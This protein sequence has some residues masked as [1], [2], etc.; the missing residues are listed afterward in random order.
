LRRLLSQL[1]SRITTRSAHAPAGDTRLS[2]LERRLARVDKRLDTLGRLATD[3]RLLLK[4][5][6]TLASA[7]GGRGKRSPAADAP[8]AAVEALQP[9]DAADW[10]TLDACPACGHR[11]ATV[12]CEY[13]RFVV[14]DVG[15]GLGDATYNYSLCHGC[16]VVFAA[17]RPTGA[18][19]RELLHAFSENLGRASRAP[20]LLNPRPLQAEERDDLSRRLSNGVFVSEH[21]GARNRD[22]LPAVLRDRLTVA[23]HV[24]MLGSLVELK[25]ARVLEIRSRTGAVG[26]ALKRLYGCEADAMP[27]FEAQQHVIQELYGIRAD[28]H[29]DFERFTI[30]YDA[31]YDLIVSNHMMTHAVCPGAFLRAVSERLRDG[32]HLYLYNEPD[33]REFL[34][35]PQSIFNVLNPFHLQTFDA[36]S[37]VRALATAGFAPVF[38]THTDMNI[39]GLF[40]KGEAA[41]DALPPRDR[42][43]RLAAYGRARDYAILALPDDRRAPFA[44]E[45]DRVVERAVVHGQATIDARGRLVFGRKL[46]ATETPDAH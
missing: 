8:S 22:W 33:E 44:G 32:G 35:R 42:A 21:T 17:R 31:T 41:A 9:A 7:N 3:Q 4:R 39:A 19:F 13:N 36:P 37:L 1:K 25:G 43:K 46:A 15:H 38:V 10:L 24:E 30:P 18:R 11:D 40:R 29:I 26:A 45:W 34:D 27:M 28:A 16:G 6:E 20:L 5:I 14:R 2:D 23:P 12:V